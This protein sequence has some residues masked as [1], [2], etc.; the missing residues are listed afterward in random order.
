MRTVAHWL[1][2]I[3]IF[4]IPWENSILVEG[5]G[6]ASRA[7]GFVVA[8]F[9]VVTVVVT[10]RFRKLRR[11][12]L[13]ICLFVLWN[14]VSALWSVNVEESMIRIQSYLQQIGLVLILWDLYTT[15]AAL[16]AGMQAYVLGAYVS[17][18]NTV[19]NYLTGSE[20][21]RYTATGFNPNAIGFILALGIPVAWYLALAECDSKKDYMLKVLNYTYFPAATF[22]ILLTASRGTLIAIVPA[23]FFVLWSLTRIKPFVRVLI[24]ITTIW[25]LFTLQTLIPQSSFQRLGTMSTVISSGEI[26]DIRADIWREGIAIFSEHPLLGVGSGAFET[27]ARKTKMPPHNTFLSVLVEVG[28]IGF[29]LFT[30]I[31]AMTVKKVL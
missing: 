15:P 20:V 28:L 7:V 1:S 12:H 11:F 6:T 27:A 18:G 31:L 10:G 9:W 3:L 2:L 17:V 22:A 8:G 5:V 19:Y 21:S 26:H 24:F 23:F 4:V 29:I 14:I 25:A 13:V 16:K 30:I